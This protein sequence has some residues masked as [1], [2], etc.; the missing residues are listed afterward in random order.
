MKPRVKPVVRGLAVAFGGLMI[1]S[2]NAQQPQVQEEVI[3]TGTRIRTPG[4]ISDSPITS[5]TAEQIQQTQPV[6]VEEFIRQLPQAAPSIGPGTNNG[7]GG[8]ATIDL[9]GL[10]ANSGDQNS[11]RTL[12]L[13]DGRRFVPFDLNGFVDTNSIPLSLLQRTDLIT[14]G[15][16]AVYG[17]DAVAGVV[18]FV[19]R[20][21]FKGFQLD[22]SYGKSGEG[23]ARRSRT[24]ITMGAGFDDGRGNVALHVGFTDVAPLRQVERPIGEVSLSSATGARQGSATTVPVVN[25][26]PTRVLDLA[27]GAFV[28]YV[29]ARD[30]FNFNPLNYYQ[31][32]LDR[33]QFTALGNYT[34]NRYAEAYAQLFF[35][36][37]DVMSNLAPS[38]TFFNDYF[39]PV[40]NPY[41]PAAA[42]Q[43]VC[44]IGGV[45]AADCVPGSTTEVLLSLGRR[46]VELGPRLNN[47]ENQT[48]QSTLGLR[49]DVVDGWTYDAFWTLGKSTQAQTRGNWGSFS[50][51]Q[52][53][54]RAVSTDEC[55]D[56]S[57]GC[58]PLNLFGGAGSITPE[59]IKFF[60]LDAVL[61]QQVE[62]KVV[63]ASLAGDLGQIRSP[64][65][66]APIGLAFGLEY[67]R[68]RAANKSDGPS[69]I[70]GEVLGTGAPTPDRSGEIEFK[71]AFAE[72]SIPIITDMDF[73]KRLSLELGYRYTD[74]KVASSQNYSSYKYGGDWEPVSGLRFRGM[75]QRATRAPNINE[76]FQPLVSGLSNLDEDPCQGSNIDPAQAN[77]PGTLSNL[78]RLTGVP[79]AAIGALP[80]PS[81]GQINVLTGGNKELG[82]EKA[83]T[84]TL[85][86]VWQPAFAQG[87][88]AT[89]DYYTIKV[90]DAISNPSSTDILDDCYSRAR[91]PS[92]AFVPA[93]AQVLR[94][95]NNGTFNGAAAPGVV[96]PLSNLGTIKT[97]GWDLAIAYGL[98]LRDLGVDPKWG[99]LDIGFVGNYTSKYEFQATPNSVNRDCLGFYS[100]ACG[101]P[102][103][104]YNFTQRTTWS[105]ADWSVFYNWRYLSSVE[106]EPGGANFLPRFSSIDAYSYFDIG[107][108]WNVHKNVRINVTISNLFDKEPPLVGN[109][110]GT[111][112]TN[113][114]NTFP[115]TYDVIGRF[116]TV[117][118]S[119]RF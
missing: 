67:R 54:L 10:S 115:Q 40:G 16:S 109:T 4:V 28:P 84:T 111:T 6:A 30:S 12:V 58:V 80:A 43:F 70:Q 2:A 52:Q 60:N 55:L 63:G 71:E 102:R 97:S 49:G 22:T 26:S 23:D 24:D 93:C 73:A 96:L 90:E 3:V 56:P 64:W 41:L 76:L 89:L 86:I 95:P 117:G 31:T 36:R 72:A 75:F 85:G 77:T 25:L 29:A 48:H 108:S 65:A 50:K 14:G 119:V 32:S 83:D 57:N 79:L 33:T 110:I 81:A 39:V 98:P 1:V 53:A 61:S 51:V 82:P 62:M 34:F 99:R 5:I 45:A 74:F 15:A 105:V 18:N 47:F 19:L 103:P 113:S 27:T 101:A 17:A 116:F 21:D 94:N 66:K 7:T 13:V 42:R 104:K 44:D 68:E 112:S 118:L 87:L 69:Q 106:E 100:I 37:S 38:G 92:L 78:C 20:R 107:G 35:T 91:N 11:N 114:G 59:M 46:F 88:T 8:G 9:R